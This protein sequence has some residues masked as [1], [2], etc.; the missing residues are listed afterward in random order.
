MIPQKSVIVKEEREIKK[1]IIVWLVVLAS[2]IFGNGTTY[3]YREE[4]D[5]WQ[6]ICSISTLVLLGMLFYVCY[7]YGSHVCA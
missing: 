2:H 5:I 6:I 7:L 1:Y 4:F 3:Y